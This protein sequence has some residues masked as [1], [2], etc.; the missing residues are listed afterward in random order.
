MR[1]TLLILLTGALLAAL[2]AVGEA[3]G[4]TPPP[5]AWATVNVC[6][7]L[8]HPNQIGIRGRMPGLARRTRMYMRFR[9]QFQTLAGQWRTVRSGADSRWHRIA[10]GRR[11]EHDAG[12]TF[13]FK[14][15]AAGGA[16]VLRG[17][18]S[19]RWRRA[20]RIVSRDRHFT[21]AGHPGTAGADPV[22]FSAATCA[23]A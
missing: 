19:F 3:A 7:T 22:D 14:P 1:R 6:D 21:E 17:V 4:R 10:S 16:H 12:Y 11:G 23:I 13:E 2:P 18:V 5:E 20:G 8:T 15:P 9:V